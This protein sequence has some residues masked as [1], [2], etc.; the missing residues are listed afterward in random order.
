[1]SLYCHNSRLVALRNRQYS[2]GSS[3]HTSR[4]VSTLLSRC[5]LLVLLETWMDVF[6]DGAGKDV[7]VFL[8]IIAVSF[9]K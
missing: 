8:L 5:H 7:V 9:V 2:L 4:V 1:M 6:F 3:A